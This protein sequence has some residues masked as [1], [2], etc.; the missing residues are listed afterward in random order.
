MAKVYVAKP[1]KVHA[2]QFLTA[3][4]PWPAAVCTAATPVGICTFEP[5]F[6]DWRPHVHGDGRIYELHD[7]DWITTS[8]AFPDR[9]PEVLTH[10]EFSEVFGAQPGT[11]DASPATGE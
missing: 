4:V 10:D 9:L 5:F 8:V 11:I 3:T 2:D 7:T 6:P 1:H